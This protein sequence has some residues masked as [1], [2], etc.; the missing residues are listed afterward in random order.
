MFAD[1]IRHHQAGRLSEAVRR[2]HQILAVN[3][4]PYPEV[5]GNL[6]LVLLQ[7]GKLDEAATSYRRALE[8]RPNDIEG[9]LNLGNILGDLGK[10][11][12]AIACYRK[13]LAFRPDFAEAHNSLGATLS[14]MGR[15]DEAV[16]S[17]RRALEIRP[18]FVM[19]LNNLGSALL[20]Q[21]NPAAALDAAK[22]SLQ[23]EEADETKGLL[24]SCLSRM[25]G[26]T[27][28]TALRPL[29]V[30]ALSEHWGWPSSL[31]RVCIDLIRLDHDIA[32]QTPLG[33]DGLA[34]LAADTLLSA[35]LDAAPICDVE[36]ER[37]LTMARRALLDAAGEPIGCADAIGFYSA[38][39]RQC[40]INEYVF[41]ATADEI[42]KASD[43]RDLLSATLETGAAVPVLWLVAVAAYFPLHSLP[44]AGR[45]LERSAPREIAALLTQQVREPA[46]ERWI[47]ATIPRLTDIED[48]VSLL[49]QRQ[50][51]EN[52][53]P[54]WIRVPP[55]RQAQ[56][57]SRPICVRPFHWPYF[58][59]SPAGSRMEILVAGCGTGQQSIRA[60]QQFPTARILAVDLSRSSL[61][62]AIRK[63]CELGVSSIEYAQ[64]DVLKL[65][66]L[67]RQFDVIE[68]G[69]VLHHLADPWTGWRLSCPCF[70]P[71]GSCCWA[72]T[73]GSPDGMFPD[74]GSPSPNRVTGRRPMR[75]ADGARTS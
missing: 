38:L 14:G 13:A 37:F 42:R 24:V 69:G 67:G 28:D 41:A 8:L 72:S 52:P 7:Q 44:L 5:H 15:L 48:D 11:H 70:V 35:L 60:F 47:R 39:A 9:L 27:T 29:M 1:A 51:E 26:V 55:A 33:A 56:T 45:L 20:A 30:R 65:G 59:R 62:Y 10:P 16:G 58:D 3:P 68:A 4:R 12:E 22:R 46:E 36:M 64:A 40:F 75:Y 17:Y 43:L 32:G 18:D 2:Y 31:M 25:R 50:Y 71:A 61:A 6:G 49:V 34:A 66:S 57:V 74:C 19:A 21:G 54:R 23:I 53:Y 63:T 73:A